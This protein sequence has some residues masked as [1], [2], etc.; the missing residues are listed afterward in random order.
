MW[1]TSKAPE[2]LIEPV[3][4]ELGAESV[5]FGMGWVRMRCPFHADSHASAA[6]NHE[7]N[8]FSCQGCGV[9]GDGYALLMSRLGIGF[10]EAKERAMSL[11]VDANPKAKRKRRMSELLGNER[12]DTQ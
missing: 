7:L 10:I 3:L 11:S 2:C 9:K 5:P 8:A 4:M 12:V 6:V 1:Q